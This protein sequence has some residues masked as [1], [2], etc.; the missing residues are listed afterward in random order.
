MDL[1]PIAPVTLLA[2]GALFGLVALPLVAGCGPGDSGENGEAGPEGSRAAERETAGRSDD[3]PDEP[4]V[5]V[6]EW[7]AR[8]RGEPPATVGESAAR[9]VEPEPLPG[10]IEADPCGLSD[11]AEVARWAGVDAVRHEA[12]AARFEPGGARAAACRFVAASGNGAGAAGGNGADDSGVVLVYEI[13]HPITLVPGVVERLF[14]H[15]AYRRV[16]DIGD[17]AGVDADVGA[18][19]ALVARSLIELR[20][21]GC[22]DPEAALRTLADRYRAAR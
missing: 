20:C 6:E 21:G 12:R 9:T 18:G 8:Q 1:R 3:A 10:P 4:L 19:W 11:D 16:E 2:L 22:A 13:R 15:P 5:S 17:E 7:L 14:T